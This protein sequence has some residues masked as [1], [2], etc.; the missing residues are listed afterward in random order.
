MF[1]ESSLAT[2]CKSR[3]R[4]ELFSQR[5]KFYCS[6]ANPLVPIITLAK[7]YPFC[8]QRKR[9]CSTFVPQ[10]FIRTTVQYNYWLVKG[11]NSGKNWRRKKQH[12]SRRQ[13][14][15]IFPRRGNQN[16]SLQS[17]EESDLDPFLLCSSLIPLSILAYAKLSDLVDGY[18][19][20]SYFCLSGIFITPRN[21]IARK[22]K[23]FPRSFKFVNV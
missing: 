6:F 4:V 21:S 11:A 9:A 18:L 12:S 23:F 17:L 3:M 13:Q 2:F 19:N 22:S 1:M 7:K 16:P 5:S 10:C 8:S 15:I 14:S 20:L